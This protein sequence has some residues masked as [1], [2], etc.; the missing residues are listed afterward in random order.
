[1]F[2]KYKDRT[3]VMGVSGGIDSMSLLDMSYKQGLN[4]IVCHVNY[5]KRESASRDQ[6]IVEEYCKQRNIPVYVR[7]ANYLGKENFQSW[8]RDFRYDFYRAIMIE[9]HCDGVLLAH[10]GDD[11]LETAMLREKQ[12]R[13]VAYYGI[14]EENYVLGMLVCRPLLGM[15]KEDLYTY[16]RE[17]HVPYGEDETNFENQYVRNT[18]RNTIL[19]TYSREMKQELLKKYIVMNEEHRLQEQEI[20]EEIESMQSCGRL[21]I[22]YLQALDSKR[23]CMILRTWLTQREEWFYHVSEHF[24]EDVYQFLFSSKKVATKKIHEYLILK[25]YE[26]LDVVED[27]SY[28][29]EYIL[30]SIQELQTP[31]FKVSF[32]GS[33]KEGITVSEE[34]LPLTIRNVREGDSIEFSFGHKKLHRYFIDQK[35]PY[36]D[37]KLC[38]VV[39]NRHQEV[40]FVCNLGS[41]I[42]H[43]SNNPNVFVVK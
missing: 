2:T 15:F 32:M 21:P 16:A 27:R 37:R 9:N 8:A 39:V 1:M 26:W 20:L 12:G 10:H 22:A 14:R 38:P 30:E 35:V 7:Y 13:E 31:Y 34:D 19:N 42:A 3:W 33:L 36:L 28:D 5:Q 17:N 24:L 40:I 18:I 25:E 23:A 11:F 41:N 6:R 43:F 4:I 29:F